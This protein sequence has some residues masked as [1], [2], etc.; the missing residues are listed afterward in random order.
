MFPD[1]KFKNRKQEEFYW[2]TVRDV[3][4]ALP[5]AKIVSAELYRVNILLGDI[6]S[7]KERKKYLSKYEKEVFK[8][9]SPS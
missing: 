1:L 9:Y 2:R 7:E 8:K 3:K 5:Y 4:R 6:K